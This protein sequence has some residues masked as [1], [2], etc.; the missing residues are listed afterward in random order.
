MASSAF[1]CMETSRFM[2]L[3]SLNL[4]SQFSRKVSIEGRSRNLISKRSYICPK[5]FQKNK[6]FTR[7]VTHTNR[8]TENGIHHNRF[9]RSLPDFSCD[10]LL[11]LGPLHMVQFPKDK[12]FTI[13]YNGYKKY[14][15]FR[16]GCV[17]N[18]SNCIG[19]RLACL[20]KKFSLLSISSM[21]FC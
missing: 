15:D 10:L 4:S 17:G 5:C 18:C 8:W 16:N 13:C 3:A 12:I 19:S 11:H 7:H 2:R 14:C 6:K 20:V 9:S 1:T 21:S